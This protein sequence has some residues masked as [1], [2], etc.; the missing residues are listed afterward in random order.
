MGPGLP[1]S[2]VLKR[3]AQLLEPLTRA[4]PGLLEA[5]YL[6]G[7]V[8]FLSGD[9]DAAQGTLQHCL[10]VDSAYSDAHI[11]MAQI[12]LHQNNF[13]AANQS[14]EVGLSYNFEVGAWAPAYEF[15]IHT[16]VKNVHIESSC[17]PEFHFLSVDYTNY[18]FFKPCISIMLAELFPQ[19]F[20]SWY[21]ATDS[22][23]GSL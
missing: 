16:P 2:P 14:L 23:E 8:K 11:L 10:A 13:K 18:L 22:I 3:C 21:I 4:V 9:V 5:L 7:K 15:G 1:A 6:M 17:D 12:H 19:T 20:V